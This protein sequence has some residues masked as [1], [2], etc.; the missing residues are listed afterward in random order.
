MT[1]ES[2]PHIQ[3]MSYVV[4]N[5]THIYQFFFSTEEAETP[6]HESVSNKL[7][8]RQTADLQL[9]QNT[10]ATISTPT[11]KTLKKHKQINYIYS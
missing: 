9:V 7:D 5:I 8:H 1:V 11:I 10:S 4:L 2:D 3:N 6:V